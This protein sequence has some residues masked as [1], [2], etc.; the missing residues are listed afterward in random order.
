[1][2]KQKSG[3]NWSQ[4]YQRNKRHRRPRKGIHR[5]LIAACAVAVLLCVGAGAA[6]AFAG[7]FGPPAPAVPGSAPP[8]PSRRQ[9]PDKA[10]VPRRQ[11]PPPPAVIPD[12][13][14]A[15]NTAWNYTADLPGAALPPLQ[16]PDYRMLALPENGRVDDSYFDDVTFVGDSIT[17]ALELYNSIPGAGYCA[18][19]GIGPRQIYDGSVQTRRTGE[20]E[21]PMEMLLAS[22]PGK[23]YVLMGTNTMVNF[24]NDSL[25]AYYAEMLDQI[26]AAL[27]AA[28]IYVQAITPVVPGRH[29]SLD[30]ARID[31]LNNLLAAL[32]LEKQLYFVNLQ[33]ALADD[34]GNLR[35]EYAGGDG[36][37]LTP[38]ACDAWREY[39]L[40]HT[41]YDPAN[42]YIA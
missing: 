35:D 41:A 38:G 15:D 13:I 2:K 8:E 29:A 28:K 23:V 4:T 27:P 3:H 31:T 7:W 22:A 40:T 1:M 18:Y 42:P 36:Y 19:K 14:L 6:L 37:H 24:D 5:A 17:Q 10:D 9:K 16:A 26:R 21:V 20:R 30:K 33:E 25:L 11:P 12:P 34:E 39:L 32:A